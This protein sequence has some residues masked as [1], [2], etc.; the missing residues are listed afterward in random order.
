MIGDISDSIKKHIN[1]TFEENLYQ[2]TRIT[3]SQKMLVIS[4]GAVN[5]ILVLVL[6]SLLKDQSIILEA[7]SLIGFTNSLYWFLF[8]YASLFL[9]LPLVRY[10]VIQSR[11]VKINKRNLQR[12]ERLHILNKGSRTIKHKLCY[13]NYFLDQEKVNNTEIAYSTEEGVIEQSDT[14]GLDT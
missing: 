3:I 12:K 10:F 2:F 1:N 7:N 4:L 8:S 5:F 13:V 6:G 14:I 9:G 11:N